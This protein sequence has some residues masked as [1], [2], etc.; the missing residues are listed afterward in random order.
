MPIEPNADELRLARTIAFKIGSRWSQVEVED[1]QSHLYL[2]LCEHIGTVTNWRTAERGSGKLYVSLKREALKYC[3]RETAAKVGQP[4]TRDNF[5][6]EAMLERALPFIFE[7]WPE[8][9]VRQNPVTGQTID[10]PFDFGNALAIMADI[11]GAFYGLP[12]EIQHVLE[13]RFR[14]G[15]TLEE[16][17]DLREIGK[18]G[19]RKLVQRCIKRLCDSLAG[20]RI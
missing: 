2:W 12:K 14:D 13:L 5:Y 9:T 15:L 16:I 8:T 19:A 18:E 11:S 7:A 6:N 17:G 20:E 3:T 1:V 10:R 4:I